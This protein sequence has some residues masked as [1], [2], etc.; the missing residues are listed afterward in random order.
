MKK[1]LTILMLTGFSGPACAGTALERLQVEAGAGAQEIGA[2]LPP[3]SP[4]RENDPFAIRKVFPMPAGETWDGPFA[5]Q[6]SKSAD[7]EKVRSILKEEKLEAKEL[8]DT[9]CGFYARIEMKEQ[10]GWTTMDKEF[11]WMRI[12]RLTDLTSVAYVFVNRRFWRD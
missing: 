9:G 6:F 11:A 1:L 4:V 2:P 8:L 10:F 3:P 12:M 5:V 7:L